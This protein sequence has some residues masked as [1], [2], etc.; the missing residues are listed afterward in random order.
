M[1]KEIPISIN[2][3]FGIGGSGRTE[4]AVSFERAQLMMQADCIEMQNQIYKIKHKVVSEN[5]FI[6]FYCEEVEREDLF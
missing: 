2:T 4:T 1:K 3:K 5:G 6:D